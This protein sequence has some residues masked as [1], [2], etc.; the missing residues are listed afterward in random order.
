MD[1][2][3]IIFRPSPLEV[4]LVLLCFCIGILVVYQLLAPLPRLIAP[5]MQPHYVPLRNFE[6]YAFVAPPSATLEVIN[7]RPIF[8]ASRKPQ[9]AEAAAPTKATPPPPPNAFLVGVISGMDQTIALVRIPGSPLETS[10]TIGASIAGWRVTKILPDKIELQAG[11][12]QTELRLDAE[13]PKDRD[14]AVPLNQMPMKS[15]PSMTG[16]N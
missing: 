16:G 3:Q 2:A 4:A 15:M 1:R 12:S 6:R 8:V 9:Q 14:A 7:A 10:V 5:Q 13:R 11:D